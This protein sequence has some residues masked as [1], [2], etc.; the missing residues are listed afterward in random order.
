M[1]ENFC[2][3]LCFLVDSLLCEPYQEVLTKYHTEWSL[4]QENFPDVFFFVQTSTPISTGEH[5]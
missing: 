1:D 3:K 5:I 4:R 2:F